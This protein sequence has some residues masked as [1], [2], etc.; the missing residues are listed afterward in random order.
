MGL[1]PFELFRYCFT[2]AG[3]PQP[4]C[5]ALSCPAA[6]GTPCHARCGR[7]KRDLAASC[8]RSNVSNG[9]WYWWRTRTSDSIT[10]GSISPLRNA[11]RGCERRHTPRARSQPSCC[12][13][14]PPSAARSCSLSGSRA[15][16]RSRSCKMTVTA[17]A[18]LRRCSAAR[19]HQ[20]CISRM[21]A[22]VPH[23]N[24]MARR[25]SA[26]LDAASAA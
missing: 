17:A 21:W 22:S 1:A 5:Q 9:H 25:D 24:V 7:A 23:R 26:P 8:P 10:H 19:R 4:A 14:S 3:Y 16:R 6:G 11:R 13:P 2:A 20:L 18:N 12:S 15:P